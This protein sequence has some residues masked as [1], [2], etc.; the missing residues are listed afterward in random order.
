[1]RRAAWLLARTIPVPKRDDGM[2]LNAEAPDEHRGGTGEL[3]FFVP[4]KGDDRHSH[5]Q[6]EIN[7]SAKGTVKKLIQ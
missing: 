2:A 7:C 3:L 4:S 5:S 6:L 1:M